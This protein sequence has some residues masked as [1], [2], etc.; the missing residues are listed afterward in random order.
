METNIAIFI[1][2]IIIL[3]IIIVFQNMSWMPKWDKKAYNCSTSLQSIPKSCGIMPPPQQSCTSGIAE[4]NMLDY[5]QPDYSN[6]INDQ[7][8]D[9]RVQQN[10]AQW[11]NDMQPWSGSNIAM[12][13]DNMDEAL[14]ANINFIG[15]RRPIAVNQ[16]GN[17]CQV[18]ELD[19]SNLAGNGN[20]TFRF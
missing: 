9:S 8:I 16:S 5:Q 11:V 3:I 12:K 15:L 7:I 17:M 1:A 6:Y 2:L 4:S 14:E 19:P 13:I 10:H 20:Y 18:T